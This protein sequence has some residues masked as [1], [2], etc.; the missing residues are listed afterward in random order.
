M[1]MKIGLVFI[2]DWELFGDGSG[3]YFKIQHQPLLEL[4]DTVE[5]HGARLTVM[6]E[7]AQQWA[8]RNLSRGQSWAGEIARSWESILRETVRRGS[9]VQFHLHPQW[10]N[11]RYEKNRWQLDLRYWAVSSLE[12]G[13]M[14]QVLKDGKDYL[15]RLLREVDPNYKCIAFRAGSYCIQ[16]SAKVIENLLKAGIICDTSV[17]RGWYEPGFYDYC[18]S[19]SNI[20]PWFADPENIKYKGARNEGLL[21]LPPYS[22][23]ALDLP[24]LKKLSMRLFY[25]L[26]SG[27]LI[28]R[29]DERWL[30]EN[31]RIFRRRYPPGRR[32]LDGQTGGKPGLSLKYLLSKI[33]SRRPTQLNY[34]FLPPAVFVGR[35]QKIFRDRSLRDWKD[36]D[37]VIPVLAGGHVKTMHNCRNID[38]IL[39]EV[40]SCLGER[41]VYWT[42]REAVDYW[43]DLIK[44][45]DTG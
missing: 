36:R 18:D 45:E 12:P 35:L 10:L 21:E 3:D 4:L 17:P 26:T 16:P 9:D 20:L 22:W 39:K 2:N 25:L 28:G 6:A 24:I 13:I 15:E 31:D 41:V 32:A 5:L 23:T 33:I 1:E 40:N 11:A 29:D 34:D 7:V 8:Y 38:R 43:L 19:H 27:A 30:R 14:E 42:L 44:E 37:V